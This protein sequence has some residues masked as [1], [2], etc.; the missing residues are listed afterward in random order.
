MD[1]QQADHLLRIELPAPIGE[2][3]QVRHEDADL[4]GLAAHLQGLRRCQDPR[5]DALA[6]VAAKDPLDEFVPRLELVLG[7]D[8]LL[9]EA[10]LLD[11]QRQVFGDA[12]IGLHVQL[13]VGVGLFAGEEQESYRLARGDQ[14]A[15]QARANPLGHDAPSRVGI[16]ALAQVGFQ[17]VEDPRAPLLQHGLEAAPVQQGRV[18]DGEMRLVRPRPRIDGPRRLPPVLDQRAPDA[19]VR[20]D[21]VE[22]LEDVVQHFLEGQPGVDLGRELRELLEAPDLVGGP[23]ED[24]AQIGDGAA[25][26]CQLV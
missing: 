9:I 26:L 6:R 23:V 2:S 8:Q 19:L 21:G 1:V 10:P 5:R 25:E 13:G 22:I 11:D 17:V 7:L 3:A 24:M 18:A 15:G 4:P 20:D 16:G 14:G 12:E